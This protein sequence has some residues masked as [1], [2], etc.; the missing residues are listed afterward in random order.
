MKKTLFGFTVLSLL[1]GTTFA[2][3]SGANSE[4]NKATIDGN[5]FYEISS[6]EEL[7]WFAEQVN[8]GY[9]SINAV[10]KKDI[11]FYEDSLTDENKG[12]A[13]TWTP[14][15]KNPENAFSGIFDGAG[16]KIQGVYLEDHDYSYINGDRLGFFGVISAKGIVKNVNF[17]K[18]YMSIS[19]PDGTSPYTSK[20]ISFGPLAAKNNGTIKD[21][22]IGGTVKFE[23]PVI[24]KDPE[25]SYGSGVVGENVGTMS[26]IV[27]SGSIISKSSSTNIG[28]ITATNKGLL[29]SVFNKGTFILDSSFVHYVGGITYDNT[30]NI[31]HSENYADIIT[32]N[33]FM[34]GG[35]ASNST[36]SL[37][38]ISHCRN[39]GNIE[40]NN[41]NES[42]YG[43]IAA[44]TMGSIYYSENYGKIKVY[45][46]SPTYGCLGLACVTDG[47]KVGGI[48]GV[49]DS[50]SGS[51]IS[52]PSVYIDRNTNYGNI[53]A[54]TKTINSLS[55]P[56]PS[57]GGI[58]GHSKTGYLTN[59]RN[60][61]DLNLSGTMGFLGSIAGHVDSAY[62]SSSI[63]GGNYSICTL[64]NTATGLNTKKG[65][66][67][68]IYGTQKI[69]TNY[70]F[71]KQDKLLFSSDSLAFLLNKREISSSSFNNT[72]AWSRGVSGP[73]LTDETHHPAF[74]VMF[75]TAESSFLKMVYT[76]STGIIKDFPTPPEKE[77]SVFLGWRYSKKTNQDSLR[78]VNL[79]VPIN[80]DY[81]LYAFYGDKSIER[82]MY[83]F[84]YSNGSIMWSSVTRDDGSIPFPGTL[85]KKASA[86]YTYTFD[87]WLKLSDYEYQATF[88]SHI[89]SYEIK[90]YK[91]C[92]GGAGSLIFKDT[93]EYGQIPEYKGVDISCP[94]TNKYD[95]AFSGTWY[96]PLEPVT[97]TQFYNAVLDST[98]RK[99]NI[100]FLNY[101]SVTVLQQTLWEYNSIPKYKGDLPTKPSAGNKIYEF[102]GWVPEP[103]N[104]TGEAFYYAKYDSVKVLPSSSSSSIVV[105]SSSI[106]VSSSSTIKSSSSIVASS[107]SAKQSSSSA[108]QSSS[109]IVK[110]SSSVAASSSSAKKSSSSVAQ[111]SSSVV[112]SSSSA[113]TSSSSKVVSSSSIA[114]SSSSVKEAS[115][116]SKKAVSS[117]SEKGS[118]V[119]DA[120]LRPQFTLQTHGRTLYISGATPDKH[121]AIM[122]LQGRI[123]LRGI[124]MT[125]FTVTLPRSGSYIV[126]LDKRTVKVHIR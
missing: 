97:G 124:S 109:S 24:D 110:S 103:T 40:S 85:S 31:R 101:D 121:F 41:Y 67:A 15:A 50:R 37:N 71:T 57:V 115:S 98:Y 120:G 20:K 84:Y 86:Q 77:D 17:E 89:R 27:F 92:N 54:Y 116:S 12:S 69:Y 22:S 75:Y 72:Q 53:T 102:S 3:W 29:D 32:K 14:I 114:K 25:I 36:D 35:I 28:G 21:V 91:N 88:I 19:Y 33:L 63:V 117:S 59:N 7:A 108:K 90:F 107:S 104:V 18:N 95:I 74:Q 9:T 55:T 125:D 42:V 105:S 119:I 100:T 48:V 94:S 45:L 13:H 8:L 126:H 43:G 11:V 51:I 38:V 66:L 68:Q 93:V 5:T 80:N 47:G 6:P 52:R 87:G 79:N 10:L 99:Y 1:S 65:T 118:R 30:A 44:Y 2:N 60:F 62:E 76:D 64:S 81:K 34:S 56:T 96:P 23:I 82:K 46:L 49:A 111:S 58:I 39:Y 122:D 113:T 73:V 26:N 112:K 16:Y 4:P 106:A 61:G 83:T 70:G 78:M 123:I